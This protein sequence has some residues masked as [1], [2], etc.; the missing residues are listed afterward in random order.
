MKKLLCVLLCAIL[1]LTVSSAFAAED[2]QTDVLVIGGGGAGISSAIAAAEKG[3]N[4]LLIE[5]VGYLGGATIISGGKIPVA[6]SRQQAAAG[7]EDSVEALARDILRPSNYSARQELVYTV[8]ENAKVVAEWMEDK[9]GVEWFLMDSL[10]Y[11][12]TQYRMLNAPENGG[13]MTRHMIEYLQSFDNITVMLNTKGTGLLTDESNA[14]IGAM[15]EGPDGAFSITAKNVVLCTSG[16]AANKDMLRKY[17]PEIVDAYPMVAP[18][19][20]GEGIEWGVKLGAAVDNMHAYQGYGFYAEGVGAFGQGIAN[21]GGI[22]INTK[23]ERFCNEYDGYSQLSPH[24]IAQPGHHVWLV[25]DQGVADKNNLSAFEEKGLLMKGDTV[26]ALA[27]ATGLDA[28]KLQHEIDMYKEGIAKG[29]DYMNRTKLP[30]SF[31]APYY[32]VY[33]TADLRHTQGGLVTDIAGH[34]LTEANEPIQG[35]YAA[36]GVTEGFSTHAGAD[37]MSGNGLLQALVFGKIAGENAAV[38]VRGEQQYVPYTG[39][40]LDNYK[41]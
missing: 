15:A 30:D 32:A 9:M 18:G 24:V 21:A 38:E 16:F 20:T 17:C 2:L 29:E 8:A 7:I 12:Q 6:N 4:V 19:A 41:N 37:Y 25:F 34:V 26:E 5:K 13:G 23:T 3:A 33:M 35:L 28:A 36:G 11:G 22:M 27:E 31:E 40:G 10:Y 14:V 1:A 39:N